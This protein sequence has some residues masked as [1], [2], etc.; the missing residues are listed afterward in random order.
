MS[1]YVTD[2]QYFMILQLLVLSNTLHLAA[3]AAYITTLFHTQVNVFRKNWDIPLGW[4]I[5][6]VQDIFRKSVE[7]VCSL[8]DA[9]IVSRDVNLGICVSRDVH[10]GM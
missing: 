5:M 3:E 7:D 9:C 8:Y 10:L 2:L 6:C 1:T 4:N